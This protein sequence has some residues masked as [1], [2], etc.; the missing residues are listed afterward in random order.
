MKL[1]FW[2]FKLEKHGRQW[3]VFSFHWRNLSLKSRSHANMPQAIQSK[4]GTDQ[5]KTIFL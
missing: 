2:I 1:F 4:T 3:N 5:D